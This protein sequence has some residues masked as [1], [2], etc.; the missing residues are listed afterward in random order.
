MPPER[1]ILCGCLAAP[2]KSPDAAPIC[3]LYERHKVPTPDAGE[4]LFNPRKPVA[5]AV[6]SDPAPA[7][8]KEC[9]CGLS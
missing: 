2:A 6:P 7:T 8:A 9:A 3:L 1:V 5:K 4:E